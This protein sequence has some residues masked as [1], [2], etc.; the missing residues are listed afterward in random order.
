MSSK[1]TYKPSLLFMKELLEIADRAK[2]TIGP[3]DGIAM[4][5]AIEFRFKEV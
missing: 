1:E 5:V 3:L 4:E 2:F